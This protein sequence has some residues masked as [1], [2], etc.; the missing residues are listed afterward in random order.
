MQQLQQGA[1]SRCLETQIKEHKD[2]A[3]KHSHIRYTRANRE[4]SPTEQHKSAITDYTSQENHVVN[5]DKVKPLV[6]ETHTRARQ[7]NE[8][9]QIRKHR[10]TMNRYEGLRGRINFPRVTTGY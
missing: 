3:E 1:T 8:A 9:I 5:W 10:H 7:I 2:D 4:A 6:K